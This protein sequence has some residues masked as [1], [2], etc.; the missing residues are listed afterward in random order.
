MQ[1]SAITALKERLKI[2]EGFRAKPYR[3]SAGK[4]TIGYG[5][6]IQDVGITKNEADVLLDGDV[7]RAL[8]ACGTLFRNFDAL[9]ENRQS[10]LADMMFNMGAAELAR[11]EKMRRALAREDFAEAVEQMKNSAWHGQVGDRAKKLVKM[12]LEG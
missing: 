2:E 6:N 11:F 8:A 9:S 12:M 10:V 7:S 4:L 5:R 3:C 1:E